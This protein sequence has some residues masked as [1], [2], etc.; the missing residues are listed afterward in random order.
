MN[1][2]LIWTITIKHIASTSV[3]TGSQVVLSNKDN[4]EMIADKLKES[5]LKKHSYEHGLLK[6]SVFYHM[7]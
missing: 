7:L 3:A 4:I 1:F 5:L 6:V 2:L